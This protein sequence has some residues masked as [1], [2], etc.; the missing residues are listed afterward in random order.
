MKKQLAIRLGLEQY[1]SHMR[2]ALG[3]VGARY[4]A[5]DRCVECANLPEDEREL[6]LFTARRKAKRKRAK[7]LAQRKE[8]FKTNPPPEEPAP[9][10]KR[11]LT[12]AEILAKRQALY[13]SFKTPA[14]SDK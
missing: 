9:Q 10:G 14:K 3:H 4:T 11:R 2:C 6:L 7:K 5:D 8:M 13:D 12:R 1:T